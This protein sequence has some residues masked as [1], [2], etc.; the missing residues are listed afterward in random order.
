MVEV[1]LP[2]DSQF[3]QDSLGNQDSLEVLHY[4][5]DLLEVPHYNQDLSV[6]P[7]NKVDGAVVSLPEPH[8]QP[9]GLDNKVD[10]PQEPP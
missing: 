8:W 1:L 7:Y 5:Q 10:G 4:K 9:D 6:L 2:A 3:K